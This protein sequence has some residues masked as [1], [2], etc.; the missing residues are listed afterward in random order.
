MVTMP[1]QSRRQQWFKVLRVLVHPQEYV[2]N[3]GPE[4]NMSILQKGKLRSSFD[5]KFWS[6]NW[7]TDSRG[8]Q[9][10]NTI[11]SP[12]LPLILRHSRTVIQIFVSLPGWE[13]TKSGCVSPNFAQLFYGY[14]PSLRLNGSK[15][16]LV[17]AGV[18]VGERG[19]RP[20]ETKLKAA[21]SHTMH[22]L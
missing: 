15:P 12:N 10:W 16:S 13:K 17:K 21:N 20:N 9:L 3:S 11:S 5:G 19:H 1:H 18:N 2:E 14:S 8:F 22:S 4:L 7:N 6:S